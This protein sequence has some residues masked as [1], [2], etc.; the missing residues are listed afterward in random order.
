MFCART[1][2]H[3]HPLGGIQESRNPKHVGPVT[4]VLTDSF[5]LLVQ[6]R[7]ISINMEHD[8]QEINHLL[9]L[10]CQKSKFGA[11]NFLSS[12]KSNSNLW[13]QDLIFVI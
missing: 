7:R 9:S 6:V 8:P 3:S 4:S 13:V 10:I 11:R 2:C 12:T 1:F 5:C